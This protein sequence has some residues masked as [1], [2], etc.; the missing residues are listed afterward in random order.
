MGVVFLFSP[1]FLGK[2]E[3]GWCGALAT[4]LSM[5]EDLS[6][7]AISQALVG[8]LVVVE[9]EIGF[10]TALQGPDRFVFSQVNLLIF[11]PAP[12][13]FDEDIVEAPASAIPAE[14]DIG[15][16]QASGESHRRELRALVGIEDLRRASL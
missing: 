2:R 11:D 5:G 9:A 1:F 4:G 13:P 8:T 14:A 6:R 10:Q 12:Q 3:I 16:L 7:N 15:V